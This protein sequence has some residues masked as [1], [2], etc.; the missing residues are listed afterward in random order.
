MS[1]LRPAPGESVLELLENYLGAL[2]AP[3][4][5][6]EF[7]PVAQRIPV[8]HTFEHEGAEWR[9]VWCEPGRIGYVALLMPI[10]S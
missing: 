8:G 5:D 7:V 1:G 3:F 9:C 4:E 10:D 2:V 6:G